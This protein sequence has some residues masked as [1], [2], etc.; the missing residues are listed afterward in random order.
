MS[1]V[2]REDFVDES[3]WNIG[4]DTAYA[5]TSDVASALVAASGPWSGT[6]IGAEFSGMQA[7]ITLRNGGRTGLRFRVREA[8]SLLTV[9][10]HVKATTYEEN[11]GNPDQPPQVLNFN[12]YRPV[13]GDPDAVDASKRLV[14][15]AGTKYHVIFE[16]DAADPIGNFALIN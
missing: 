1:V 8:G 3:G 16:N 12:L 13:A 2:D 14:M 10:V 15:V 6:G 5:D 11:T 4:G 7:N 9:S